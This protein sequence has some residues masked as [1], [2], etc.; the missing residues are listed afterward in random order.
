MYV[1]A[2]GILDINSI[3]GLC[4]QHLFGYISLHFS[5]HDVERRGETI[6]C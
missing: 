2:E 4:K 3:Y 6:G 5:D 1:K